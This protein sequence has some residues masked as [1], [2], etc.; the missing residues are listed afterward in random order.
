MKLLGR[1]SSHDGQTE[2]FIFGWRRDLA[3]AFC[4]RIS[5]DIKTV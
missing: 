4:V 2:A 3:A 1:T 5:K